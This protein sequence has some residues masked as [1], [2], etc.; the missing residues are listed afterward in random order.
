MRIHDPTVSQNRKRAYAGPE[1]TRIHKI[2]TVFLRSH[3]KQT[4]TTKRPN[5]LA[6]P[7][8]TVALRTRNENA[9]P[10]AGPRLGKAEETHTRPNV[11]RRRTRRFFSVSQTRVVKGTD[12]RVI[13]RIVVVRSIRARWRETRTKPSSECPVN[14]RT[15][16]HPKVLWWLI[17]RFEKNEK[18]KF[19][20]SNR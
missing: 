13:G 2:A 12:N 6:W 8:I 5:V 17:S 1:N 4:A 14:R 20:T 9:S 11:V 18:L 16:Y 3:G 19:G 7:I 10:D 15:R